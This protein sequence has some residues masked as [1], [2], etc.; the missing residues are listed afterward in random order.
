[1]KHRLWI[2]VSALFALSPLAYGS[3]ID[4]ETKQEIQHLLDYVGESGC[5]Y[6]RNGD[7]HQGEEAV[8]HIQK[9]YDYFVDDIETT[10]D[11]IAKSATQSL[12]SKKKYMIH[13]P[14]QDAVPSGDWLLEELDRYR[15]QQSSQTQ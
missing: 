8:E 15:E 1:M 4:K 2:L 11:F 12:I 7:F 13:C 9:K 10:E 5:K 14:Q 3:E 6:E